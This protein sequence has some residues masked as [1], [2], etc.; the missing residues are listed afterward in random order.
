MNHSRWFYVRRAT[1]A[2]VLLFTCL[3]PSISSSVWAQRLPATV[4]PNHY[5]LIF[6]PDLKAATYTGTETID[7]TVK[8]PSRSITL[9]S[10]E[11]T[12]DSVSVLATGKRQTANV[13][14]DTEKEQ[15]TFTFANEIPAGKA[16]LSIKYAGILNNQLRGFYLSKTRRRNYAVTQFEPTDARRAFP[17]FDE[18]AMK[19]SFDI[20]LVIDALDT[21]I[22]NGPIVSDTQGP[23]AGKHTLRFLTTPRMSSYL[24]AFLVGDFECTSGEQDGVSIRV[25][26]TPDK[27]ALTHY[28]LDVAKYALHYY[29]NY[30]GIPYPL[31]KLDLIGLPDFDAGAMENFGAIT[32]RETDLLID[33]KAATD[34][35]K[36]NVALVVAHEIAHQWFGD[37]V[38]MKWWDN[39]WLN[40]GFATWMEYKVVAAMHPD[41][42]M[43]QELANSEDTTLGLDSQPTTRA[44]RARADTPDEIN[45]MFD[46]IAYG[47]AGAV[48]LTVENYLGPELFRKG[49]HD[50]LQAHLY[51]N[52]TAEDFW[53][54]QTAVSHKPVNK[55]MDALVAQPGVPLLSFGDP[56]S[57]QV[58]VE[59]RRFFLSPS[60]QPDLKQKWTLPVCFKSGNGAGD[61]Q[62]LTPESSTLRT[63]ESSIFFANA[64][65]KGYYRSAYTPAA[66]AKIVANIESALTPVERISIAGDEWAQVRSNRAPVGDYLDLS[67][68]L[69]GDQNAEVVSAALSGVDA[70]V[71]RVA[72]TPEEKSALAAWLRRTFSP[73]LE[74]LGEPSQSDTPESKDLR[75]LLF[76]VLGIYGNDPK[77]LSQAE[78]IAESY[79]ADPA[80]VDPALGQSALSVAARHGDAKLFDELQKV[81][82]TSDDPVRQSIALH[83]MAQFEDPALVK[84]SLD[85][86]TSGK[87]RNQDVAMQLS[88][89]LSMPNT[90][91]LA[92]NYVKSHWER[93]REQLT[94]DTGGGRLAGATGSFCSA[95]M[96]EDVRDF[97]STHKVAASERALNQAL[98]RI[99]G[100]MEFRRLQEPNLKKWLA[101]QSNK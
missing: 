88:V 101:A 20:S 9:N 93:V 39:L 18:P 76:D 87:V 29:N 6:T 55:I 16:T 10:A 44:I 99:K 8:A 86:A 34:A 12:F 7:I 11:I 24:V 72:A 74:K 46:G 70:I 48:L 31:K 67:A 90:R 96:R 50:Y 28:G 13:N 42:N 36:G 4:I 15:A 91:D 30:F 56:D 14:L 73:Q 98:E 40:E 23:G 32:Y 54:V 85:Y 94:A 57:G 95:E 33:P 26:A 21:G 5:G 64:G 71:E 51:A 58:P 80:S 47:K 41:W 3:L 60:I 17:S 69:K 62:L 97:F 45:E 53:N 77:V 89:S 2:T 100:C 83:M 1:G 75:V 61:C 78:T 81:Y 66:Y 43:D 92:W 25:C 38:T 65:G 68:A 27:V 22:S 79:L 52:A 84:R 35:A 82:E 19:A 49:V 37:L 59:Q 63:P